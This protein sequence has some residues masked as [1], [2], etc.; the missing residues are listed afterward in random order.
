[1]LFMKNKVFFSILSCL[2]LTIAIGLQGCGQQAEE[3]K[4]TPNP[5]GTISEA[6]KSEEGLFLVIQQTAKD[7]DAFIIAEKYP[8]SGDTRAIL[9]DMEGNERILTEEELK[10]MAEAEAAKVEE[11][12]SNLTQAPVAESP[13][14]SLGETILAG[15]AGALI[16]GMIANKLAGNSNYQQHQQQQQAQTSAYQQTQ[17]SLNRNMGSSNSAPKTGLFSGNKNN[18]SS[19]SSSSSSSSDLFNKI[20]KKKR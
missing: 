16:G 19:S 20:N 9:K 11:G 17:R 8:S 7:P 12:T 15:A 18:N 2:G 3:P 5:N 13:G 10:K 14:L 1:M 4:A 6:A